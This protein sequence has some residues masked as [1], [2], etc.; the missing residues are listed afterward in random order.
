MIQRIRRSRLLPTLVAALVAAT[1]AGGVASAVSGVKADD[2]TITMCVSALGTKIRFVHTEEDCNAGEIIRTW[3]MEGQRGARG[4]RGNTGVAGPTGP[5]GPAGAVGTPASAFSGG[6]V[7]DTGQDVA[8]YV[9][10][11]A[12]AG[13]VSLASTSFTVPNS[14][15][16]YYIGWTTTETIPD[17]TAGCVDNVRDT[18]P[19]IQVAVNGVVNATVTASEG[20][21]PASLT[22][23]VLPAGTNTVTIQA[24]QG[25]CT[26]GAIEAGGTASVTLR[27]LV[28]IMG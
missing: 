7:A 15:H 2:E 13:T 12:T 22:P 9:A 10:A 21:A 6:I 3:N 24:A 19:A 5:S 20:T 27:R 28:I 14:S 4:L 18:V 11:G 8:F 26:T 25:R 16:V 17:A 23:V 1:M